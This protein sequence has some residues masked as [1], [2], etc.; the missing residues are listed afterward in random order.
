MYLTN[1]MYRTCDRLRC[2]SCDFRVEHFDDYEWHGS[3]DYLFFRNN[4]PDFK[5][6]STKLRRKAGQNFLLPRVQ[7]AVCGG[8]VVLTAL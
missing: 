2:T 6:I 4:M 3:V 5:K 1:I 8:S 7:V